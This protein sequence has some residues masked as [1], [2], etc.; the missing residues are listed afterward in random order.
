MTQCSHTSWLSFHAGERLLFR[1]TSALSDIV[2][3][4][5]APAE[6]WPS[7]VVLVDDA[8]GGTLI[9]H[10]LPRPS[11]RTTHE[12]RQGVS[13]Q[14]DI[15]NPSRDRP[16]FIARS[17][18]AKRSKLTPEPDRALCHWHTVCELPAASGDFVHDLHCQILYPFADVV[19]LFASETGGFDRV[20]EHIEAW[21]KRAR[22]RPLTSR[23]RMLIIAAPD[24]E[25][26][27]AD[28]QTDVLTRLQ[29]RIGPLNEDLLLCITVFVN[30]R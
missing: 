14:L 29:Q 27:P 13:L 4:L 6:T 23:P 17:E 18:I 24:E 19:C 1:Q 8:K 7:L 28:V 12:E 20:V 15:D 11:R 10:V 5:D 16:V 22:E 9:D 21:C 2:A 30:R 26:N 25:R 3:C